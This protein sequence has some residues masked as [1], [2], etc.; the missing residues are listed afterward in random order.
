MSNASAILFSQYR[1]LSKEEDA[2]MDIV[3][4]SMPIYRISV[5]LLV[6][7]ALLV[8]AIGALYHDWHRP[9]TG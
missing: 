4:P 9:R 5:A 6:G 8:A 1:D 2:G 7:L 3:N